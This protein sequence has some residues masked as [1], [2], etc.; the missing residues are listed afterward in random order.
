MALV[1]IPSM[2]RDL[3]SG[4]DCVRLPGATVGEVIDAL[5][6]TYPGIK[7]RLLKQGRFVAGIMVTVDGRRALRGLQERVG[8]ESEV[9]FLPIISGG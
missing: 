6:E 4:Q 8:G 7:D 3:S 5:E 2:I 1:W 9:R